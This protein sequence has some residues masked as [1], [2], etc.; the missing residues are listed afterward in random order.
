MRKSFYVSTFARF[1]ALTL[2]AIKM[3]G[4]LGLLPSAAAAAMDVCLV[5]EIYGE[6]PKLIENNFDARR[7]CWPHFF[8]HIMLY[9][10]NSLVDG[11]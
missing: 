1:L 2:E 7:H 11:H 4:F 3:P 9:Q 6:K 8:H 10:G 5:V